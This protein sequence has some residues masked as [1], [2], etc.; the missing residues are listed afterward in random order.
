MTDLDTLDAQYAAATP[1]EWH[2]PCAGVRGYA[3]GEVYSGDAR[4]PCVE[5]WSS[6]A[7]ADAEWIAAIHNAYP[8]LVA[9]LRALR[10]ERDCLV[11]ALRT[12]ITVLRE[13]A[14]LTEGGP[15]GMATA[16]VGQLDA[17][18]RRYNGA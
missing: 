18:L 15:H 10:Q 11:A 6:Q 1:G 13:I 8:A 12:T 9:E 3:L 5:T 14:H 16:A 2:V 7:G 17:L 4:E